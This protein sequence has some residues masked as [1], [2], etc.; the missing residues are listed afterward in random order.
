MS[1]S[2]AIEPETHTVVV[3]GR[4]VVDRA[5]LDQYL[6]AMTAMGTKGYRKLFDLTHAA[7]EVAA[8]DMGAVAA[9]LTQFGQDKRAGPVAIVIGLSPLSVDTAV[10]LKRHVAS[11]RPLRIFTRED[12]ARRWLMQMPAA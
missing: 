4:G 2:W 10:L 1:M 7:F 8:P 5:F 9:S 11:T 12:E 6:T 3:S